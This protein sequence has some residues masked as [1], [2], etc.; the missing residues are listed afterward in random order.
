MKTSLPDVLAISEA[1]RLPSTCEAIWAASSALILVYARL[2]PGGV[3]IAMFTSDWS[4]VPKKLAPT[5]PTAGSASAPKKDPMAISTIA[6][7]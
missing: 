5:S 2:D 4:S 7:R 1:E 3:S 6:T